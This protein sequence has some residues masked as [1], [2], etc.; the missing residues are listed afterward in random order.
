MY[1]K[2]F[3][4]IELLVSTLIMATLFSVGYAN[5]R[6]YSRKQELYK[7]VRLFEGYLKLAQRK[8]LSGEGMK[9]VCNTG[10]TLYAYAVSYGSS[11]FSIKAKC[12]TSVNAKAS[13]VAIGSDNISLPTGL[14]FNS[15]SSALSD[16]YLQFATV[17][18]STNL[19]SDLPIIIEMSATGDTATIT[20]KTTGEIQI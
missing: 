3:T 4:L 5:L 9:N 8:A 16:D 7:G 6:S 11:T 13:F 14:V 10:E 2:G 18:G 19:S 1:K 12:A 20:V 15:S 17:K